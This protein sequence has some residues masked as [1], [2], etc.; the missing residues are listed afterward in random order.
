MIGP[1][2]FVAEAQIPSHDTI[3]GR[4][5]MMVDCKILTFGVGAGSIME[6][7]GTKDSI[8]ILAIRNKLGIIRHK[9]QQFQEE[10]GGSSCVNL[11]KDEI[12]HYQ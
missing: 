8:T 11:K 9:E 3:S 1:F 2:L 6:A 10:I 7:Y 12:F 4:G 5:K